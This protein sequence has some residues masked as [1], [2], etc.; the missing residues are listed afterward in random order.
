MNEKTQP[1]KS[2]LI[3]A[4]T[5]LITV[6][7]YA[8]IREHPGYHFLHRELYFI[9]ILLTSFWFGLRYGLLSALAISILYAP[10]AF[11]YTGPHNPWLTVVTQVLIFILVASLL[12]WLA[13]RQKKE[14]AEAVAVE[15]L[16]VLGRAAGVVGDEMKYLLGSLKKLAEKAESGC[17][18][19]LT[20]G[21]KKET[22][23][24]EHIVEVLAA[25]V[26]EEREDLLSCDINTIIR[27]EADKHVSGLQRAGISLDVKIDEAGCPTMVNPTQIKRILE[28]LIQN[29]VEVSSPGKTISIRSYRKDENCIVEVT[30]QGPGI[31]PEHL[32]KM[33]TPFFTTKRNGQ[34]LALAGSRKTL[35]DMGGDL[36]V[37]SRLGEGATF[38][39]AIPRDYS[40]KPLINDPVSS[41]LQGKP[42][43]RLYRE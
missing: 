30:D 2:I 10:H 9:P 42:R 33:F 18:P 11:Y 16:A 34:G 12:G 39:L 13:D 40:G 41:T 20:L 23:R 14:H 25:F 27:K 43:G 26:S 5:A 4:L 36:Y 15:N 17:S 8:S 21:F 1:Y 7:H 19:E 22:D 35:R 29:A 32:P 38:T 37:S 28:S 3:I 24:M 6:M 31:R